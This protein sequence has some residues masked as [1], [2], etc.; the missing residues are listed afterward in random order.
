MF[1]DTIVN[2]DYDDAKVFQGKIK[3]NKKKKNHKLYY[4]DR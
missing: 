4:Q 3:V 2:D 1:L